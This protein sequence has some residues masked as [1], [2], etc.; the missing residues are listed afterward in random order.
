M[1]LTVGGDGSILKASKEFDSWMPPL[2]SFHIRPIAFMS[3]FKAENYKKV[4]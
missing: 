1:I 2:L 4:I 3:A